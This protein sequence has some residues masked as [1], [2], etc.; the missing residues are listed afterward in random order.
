MVTA[1]W[2]VIAR[3]EYRVHTSAS[4]P[5]LRRLRPLFPYLVAL[6]LVIHVAYVSPAIMGFFVDDA[7]SFFISRA[8]LA[9]IQIVLFMLFFY[10]LVIPVTDTL[11]GSR[12]EQIETYLGAPVKPGDILLGEYL[13]QVPLYAVLITLLAGLFTAALGP[14]GLDAIQT[15]IVIAIF[16]IVSLSALWIGTVT[17]ALLRTRLAKA[18]RG[19]DIGKALAV[20]IP[21]PALAVAYAM[22]GGGLLETL[23]DPSTSSTVGAVLGALP[24]S[25][26]AKI[27]IGFAANPGEIGALGMGGAIRFGG[28]VLFFAGVL[29]MG[30]RFAGRAI[31][32]EPAEF[33][34]PTAK[35]GGRPYSVLRFLGG[36]GHSGT[37]LVSIFKDYIRRLENLTNIAYILGLFVIIN[38]F[39]ISESYRPD[40]PPAHLIII[41]IYLP[42]LVAM[43]TGDEEI[44]RRRDHMIYRQTPSGVD[45]YIRATLVKGWLMAAPIAMI[46]TAITSALRP[47]TTP[48]TV[49]VTTLLMMLICLAYGPLILG[50]YLLNPTLK[51]KFAKIWMNA[52]FV[53]FGSL[54]FF[55]VSIQITMGNLSIMGLEQTG[56]IPSI[57]LI[58]AS[59]TWLAALI[60]LY[61]GKMKLG[62]PN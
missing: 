54:G 16:V 7:T 30:S 59:A 32:L 37:I 49:L 62:R 57:L 43:V 19:K 61:L 60:F 56:R 10:L 29:L 15:A 35:P 14:L 36:R 21:L 41:L 13:G 22:I 46:I 11:R 24:S 47:G 40:G 9:T 3:N 5:R 31:T 55:L 25:W 8:A 6:F 20:M 42:V 18:S 17:A 39:M 23:A 12:I 1:K 48:V 27:I 26:G 44:W 28:L 52:M 53:A 50:I 2:L 58:Q 33:S 51:E 38:V 45:K 4:S 34:P